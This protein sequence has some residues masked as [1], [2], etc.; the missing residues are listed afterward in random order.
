MQQYRSCWHFSNPAGG[1]MPWFSRPPEQRHFP[2]FKADVPAIASLVRET[3]IISLRTRCESISE[4]GAGA[5]GRGME[6]L[7]VGDLVTLQLHFPVSPQPIWVDTI[8]RYVVLHRRTG[9]CGFQFLSLSEDQLRL[10]RRYCR[11]QTLK[12]RWRWM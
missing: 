10:I 9:E 7:R 8:V 5:R 12:K 4:G 6:P 3:E 1:K 2:R 11:L